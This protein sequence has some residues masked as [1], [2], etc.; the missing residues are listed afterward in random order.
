MEGSVT[1]V[2]LDAF[3]SWPGGP[4]GAT[5]S[6]GKHAIT[7]EAG[8]ERREARPTDGSRFSEGKRGSSVRAWALR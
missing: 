4:A 2:N 7:G 5:A 3:P 1:S 6:D 8:I